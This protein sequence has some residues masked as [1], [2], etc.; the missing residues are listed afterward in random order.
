MTLKTD[1]LDLS[2]EEK[3]KMLK[4]LEIRDNMLLFFEKY[5]RDNKGQKLTLGDKFRHMEE[6]YYLHPLYDFVV[7]EA[8]TQIG[9]SLN[10]TIYVLACAAAGLSVMVV[11]PTKKFKD[12]YYQEKFASA[13]AVSQEYQKFKKDSVADSSDLMQF[14]KGLIKFVSAN[15]TAD[16]S[17]SFSA[18][19]V[20]VE[21]MDQIDKKG[22]EN[23]PLA[24]GRMDASDYKFVRIISNSKNGETH[25]YLQKSDKRV[26]MSPCN[27]CGEFSKLDF[28]DTVVER[29]YDSE[30]NLIGAELRDKQWFPGGKIDIQ[31]KCPCDDCD[32]DLERLSEKSYWMPTAFS[33]QNIVGYTMPSMVSGLVKISTLWQEYKEA[34]DD[35]AK[36][37]A[38]Y[39]R[40]LAIPFESVGNKISSSAL[41]RCCMD[42]NFSFVIKSEGKS[43]ECYHVPNFSNINANLSEFDKTRCVMGVDV[44]PT[45]LDIS[46]ASI[47]KN[48]LKLQFVAKMDPVEKHNLLSLID[49]YNI[50]IGVIDIGPERLYAN[51]LQDSVS[52]PIWKCKYQ[53]AGDDRDAKENWDELIYTVD[54]TE[55]LDEANGL[56]KQQQICLPYNFEAIFGGI[57]KDEMTAL[58]RKMKEDK[59]GKGKMYWDGSNNDHSFHSLAYLNIAHKLLS[60]SQEMGMD[61][62]YIG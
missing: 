57:W 28:F 38:F 12:A 45:H 50:Q 29:K 9:K 31:V 33:E 44:S 22:M 36:M 54:R 49:R 23:L 17:A 7:Q 19:V 61:D 13:I 39:F 21:E 62:I 56:I 34:M 42:K 16:M 1:L 30:D 8:S 3:L 53:G 11:L 51:W 32:G 35:P 4:K 27:V 5:H 15:I 26:R 43:G 55:A 58:S 18:D 46:I 10:V 25:K 20:V 37:A 47:E 40:R 6:S 52:I 48:G 2:R 24:F 60:S 41:K 59:K 14:G